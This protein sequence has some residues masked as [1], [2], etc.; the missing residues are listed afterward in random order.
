ME[1][2]YLAALIVGGLVLLAYGGDWI[3]DGG[4]GLAKALGLTPLVIGIVFLGFATSIP[5][6]FT[7][8]NGA[9]KGSPGVALGNVIGSNIA[10]LLLIAGVTAALAATQVRRSMIYR[11]GGFVLLSSGLLAFLIL[12]VGG[13]SAYA[14][15]GLLMVLAV[16]L[17]VSLVYGRIKAL[18][19]A[20]KKA[21]AIANGEPP[22]EEPD[23]ELTGGAA[24]IWFIIGISATFAGAYM[25]VEGAV[26]LA[27]AQ[28]VSESLIGLTIVAFGTSLP[29]LAAAIAAGRKGQPELI[30][31]NVLGSNVFN[32]GAV[33]GVTAMVA[34]LNAPPDLIQ[35]DLWVMM[36]G[37]ALM[38]LLAHRGKQLSRFEGVVLLSCYVAY[39]AF[40]AFNPEM[41][42]SVV[43]P[44]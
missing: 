10:N 5:E 33:V 12:W 32:V 20:E 14:G 19:A 7:S 3:V 4:V 24:T 35:S 39:I 11:D 21:A 1:Y 34:P 22:V 27:R 29:E 25:L 23:S 15:F 41:R 31:G 8:L 2:A 6:L 9:L 16:Y 13:V 17:V 36:V 42:V 43:S 38:L 40:V 44:I 30:V 37:T 26:G 18:K 28:G